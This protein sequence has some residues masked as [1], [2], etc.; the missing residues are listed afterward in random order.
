[1]NSLAEKFDIEEEEETNKKED[2]R[3]RSKLSTDHVNKQFLMDL[4]LN[5]T[6]LSTLPYIKI[7]EETSKLSF[8]FTRKIDNDEKISKAI[9][10]KYSNANYSQT[11]LDMIRETYSFLIENNI[12]ESL[13]NEDFLEALKSL[14]EKYHLEYDENKKFSKKQK[15]CKPDTIDR[16][17]LSSLDL[18]ERDLH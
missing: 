2:G 4:D 10:K 18:S 12:L 6:D 11:L 9:N 5:S 15:R 7:H 13:S 1:M 3:N 8:A 17:F 14:A 16:D